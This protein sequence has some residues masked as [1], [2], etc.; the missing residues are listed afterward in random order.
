MSTATVERPRL[1][2]HMVW[3]HGGGQSPCGSLWSIDGFCAEVFGFYTEAYLRAYQSVQEAIM[4]LDD[5]YHGRDADSI[6][7]E[8]WNDNQGVL[9]PLVCRVWGRAMDLLDQ[10]F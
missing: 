8:D 9:P 3:Q 2:E 7:V 4:E 10:S 5:R 6:D 1:E